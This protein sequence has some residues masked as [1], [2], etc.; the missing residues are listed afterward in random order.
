MKQ[1]LI[2]MGSLLVALPLQAKQAQTDWLNEVDIQSNLFAQ[3]GYYQTDRETAYSIP[4]VVTDAKAFH[5]EEGL[6]LMHGE[7]GF[8]ASLDNALAAKL[9]IGSHHGES[10]ELEELW[11]QPHL[12]QDWTLRIGRQLSPIGLYNGV[13]EHDWRFLDASLTQQ[14][15]LGSCLLY[16]SPSPRD[17]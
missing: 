5:Y 8:L 1:V 3:V 15:F 11:L 16:T 12:H 14:A 13:H 6:Q 10:I 7:L 17:T 9:I 4:G 2:T